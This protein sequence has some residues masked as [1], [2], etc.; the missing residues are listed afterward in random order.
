MLGRLTGGRQAH[1]LEKIVQ[2][3][4]DLPEVAEEGAEEYLRALVSDTS[5]APVLEG[6][7]ET[8]ARTL[9]R[10]NP[11]HAKR[12]LND[13]S[14]RLGLLAN[15]GKLGDGDDQVTEADV[16]SWHLLREAAPA[17]KWA[18][19]TRHRGHLIGFLNVYESS[20]E[21]L[22]EGQD[23]TRPESVAEDDFALFQ[24]SSLR[25]H[26]DRLVRLDGPRRDV[27]V[28]S[29]VA[30]GRRRSPGRAADTLG[31]R[32]SWVVGPDSGWDVSDGVVRCRQGAAGAHGAARPVRDLALSGD[33]RRVRTIRQ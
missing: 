11:R 33:Q 21:A 20:R 16:L 26:L 3:E 18:Y 10:R 5:L 13:L 28:P 14:I 2:V 22:G 30:A 15:T 1:F 29:R 6:E 17:E 9:Q 24:R 12:F 19:L 8:V 7:V 25:P 32:G 23:A 4:V 27:L 31:P